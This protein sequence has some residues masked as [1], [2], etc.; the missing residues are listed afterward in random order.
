MTAAAQLGARR[1]W[2]FAAAALPP[3]M[4]ALPVAAYLPP[5]YARHGG[6]S[7]GLIGLIF[8]AARIIDL[9]TDPLMGTLTD[10]TRSRWGARRPWLVA[11]M[12]VLLL[13]V[14][15]LFFPPAG[16]GAWWLTAALLVATLGAKM[17]TIPH[18]AW[19]VDIAAG[20][21]DRSRVQAAIQMVSI[22][23]SIGSML[24]PAMLEGQAADPVGLRAS[25][26]GALLL[27][28]IVPSIGMALLSGQDG[29]VPP[30]PEQQ[31]VR[32][33][34]AIAAALRRQPYLRRLLAA[35]FIQGF[36]GG[37]LSALSF[38]VAL[39]KGVGDRA[40]LLILC[41]FAVGL[42]MI[43]AWS[44][45]SYRVGKAATIGWASLLALLLLVGVVAAPRGELTLVCAA[46]GALGMTS[47]VWTFLSKA[48][49]ADC[50][51]IEERAVRAPRAGLVFALL[52]LVTKLGIALSVGAAFALLA[53]SGYVAGT[54][55]AAAQGNTILALVV[56]VALLG[57][58]TMAWV[59]FSAPAACGALARDG[60]R[61]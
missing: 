21:R 56:G 7:L 52:A 51:E 53:A 50:V 48:I 6:L 43:P 16:A 54:P 31:P 59:A 26:L 15:A 46:F 30:P 11:A 23:G 24:I 35:N 57:H 25:L 8:M 14:W 61:G 12:P 33:L 55:M 40:S 39:A 13:S 19:S 27:L 45:L 4:L 58:A 1:V 47:G 49:V 42:C 2:W 20:A 29:R 17:L 10:R 3:A 36:A 60:A 32:P 22:A 28:L 38:Y 18:T 44:R 9:L 34:P 41:Y 37:T 5:F